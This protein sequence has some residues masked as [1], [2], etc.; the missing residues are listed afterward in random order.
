MNKTLPST[1]CFFLAASLLSAAESRVAFDDNKAEGEMRILVDG[2]EALV[3]Q[4]GDDQDMVHFYPVRSPD[5]EPMTV[6]KTDPYPHHRS[7]WF[8]DKVQLAGERTVEF[9]GALYSSVS[10]RKEP[11]PPFKDHIRHVAFAEGKS[12]KDQA[13]VSARLIWEMD[14]AKPVLDESRVMRVVA[15]GEGE[16]L[17]DIT[18]KLTAAYGDVTFLSDA[19]HYAWPFVRIS[20][21]FSVDGGGTITNSEG[22]VN[23]AE[24]NGKPARWV[25]YSNTVGGKTSGLAIF[26][27]P[28]TG[29]E[30]PLWLTRDYGCFGPRRVADKSGKPFTL[31]KGDSI[32]QRV[33]ILVHRG[34][35][36]AGSVAA[37]YEAYV[38]GKM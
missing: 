9:Y 23:Q 27:H 30:S 2:K 32:S 28:S 5:G 1:L 38:S 20:A 18:Y 31:A 4:Y 3:Y 25:D 22:G 15:L 14:A 6:Q 37:R 17:L 12:E 10:G 11:K 26:P 19:V 24:T 13:S 34:D 7:F 21:A 33:G 36:K 8:A 16:W 35:V 29:P